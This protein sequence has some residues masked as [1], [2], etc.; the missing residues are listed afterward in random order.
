MVLDGIGTCSRCGRW[1]GR[2]GVS[3]LE[4][5]LIQGT[6]RRDTENRTV[7]EQKTKANTGIATVA[8]IETKTK[9][10]TEMEMEME[11]GSVTYQFDLAV[12]IKAIKY[13]VCVF[14]LIRTVLE[15]SPELPI[16]LAD[17]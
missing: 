8:V 9:T 7:T 14:I 3:Q 11:T 1:F 13:Q 6:G 2:S 16:G 4:L 17:P 12:S 10:K 5:G 15:G